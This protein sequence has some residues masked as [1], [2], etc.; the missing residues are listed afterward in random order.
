M[1]DCPPWPWP[2]FIYQNTGSGY[3]A[4]ED[5]GDKLPSQRKAG[6]AGLDVAS[7][8]SQPQVKTELGKGVEV[9]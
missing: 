5:H 6:Q 2:G 1:H 8:V 4:G 9:G 7:P 3:S